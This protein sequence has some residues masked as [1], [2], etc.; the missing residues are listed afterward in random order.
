MVKIHVID[1]KGVV[2]ER[3]FET[4]PI[5]IGRSSILDLSLAD[6]ALSRQHARISRKN[7]RWVVEDLGSRNSTFVNEV[8]LEEPVELRLGD[9]VSVGSCLLEIREPGDDGRSANASITTGTG[10]TLYR[11]A[12]ELV[13]QDHG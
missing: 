6:R 7:G 10:Q 3:V 8:R 12:A 5:V 4:D 1:G 2:S 13:R 9:R 11:S